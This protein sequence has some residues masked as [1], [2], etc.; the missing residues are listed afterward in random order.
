VM[1]ACM[2]TADAGCQTVG[3]RKTGFVDFKTAESANRA[4]QG[5]IPGTGMILQ[6]AQR[7]YPFLSRI[8]DP[9]SCASGK[10]TSSVFACE[11][12][13][14]NVVYFDDMVAKFLY[15]NRNTCFAWDKIEVAIQTKLREMQKHKEVEN[16]ISQLSKALWS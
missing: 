4:I 16:K 6:L 12:A 7:E 9:V 15:G 14:N 3:S 13:N 5:G 2:Q 10:T 11:L 8:F 1:S